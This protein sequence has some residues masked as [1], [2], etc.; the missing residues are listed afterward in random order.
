MRRIHWALLVALGG[1][2]GASPPGSDAVDASVARSDS[3]VDAGTIVVDAGSSDLDSGQPPVDAGSNAV[4]AGQPPVDAGKPNDAGAIV[5][6]DAGVSDAGSPAACQLTICLTGATERGGSNTPFDSICD[7]P[8]I[9]GVISSCSGSTC[10]HTFNTFLVNTKNTLYPPLFAALDTNHDNVVNAVDTLCDVNILGFSWGGYAGVELAGVLAADTRVAA[11]RR[12]V[13]RLFIIDPYQPSK[14][15]SVPSNV[16]RFVEYRHSVVPS[17]SD[18]S[19]GAPL[20]PYKGLPPHCPAA[21][22]CI[23]F[24]YSL[25]PTTSFPT[26]TGSLLGSEVGHCAVPEVAAP[27]IL[28]DF[29]GEAFSPLPPTVPVVP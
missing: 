20:G 28:A 1:A 24:D 22:N 19:K 11:D 3:G 29:R 26:R 10:F 21:Q 4:D 8:V 17:G 27:P 15:I 23:D 18:C 16:R 12:G 9:P 2:C 6:V 7:D 14:N 5:I 25:A 13:A